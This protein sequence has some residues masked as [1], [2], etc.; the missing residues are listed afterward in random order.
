LLQVARGIY[1]LIGGE[2]D[3]A[4][5]NENNLP[6]DTKVLRRLAAL[7]LLADNH[8]TPTLGFW[9]VRMG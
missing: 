5:T 8:W 2:V 1:V 4:S 3:H 6:D 7:N 9:E